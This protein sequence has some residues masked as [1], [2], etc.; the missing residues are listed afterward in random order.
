MSEHLFKSFRGALAPDA[1]LTPAVG[2]KL[3]AIVETCES[4]WTGVRPPAEEFVRHLGERLAGEPDPE[5]LL[6]SLFVEDLYLAY[7]CALGDRVA[8]AAFERE[9]LVHVGE[10]VSR[11]DGAAQH[12]DE[13]RQV[14]RERLLV[15]DGKPRVLDYSGRGALGGWV[16]V[17]AVR[18]ALNVVQRTRELA[19]P[20]EDLAARAV[21]NTPDPE[22]QLLQARYRGEFEAAVEEALGGLS[23]RDCNLM[24][25]HFVDGLSV[26]R[27][28]HAYGVH[29]VTVTRWLASARRQLL[30]RTRKILRVRLGLSPSEIDSLVKILQ[31]QLAISISQALQQRPE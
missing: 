21:A 12:L 25:L 26:E 30:A 7:A 17:A 22:L 29:R 9:V 27:I 4:R 24:R 3:A 2:E 10:F 15:G 14:L 31:S 28:R 1:K 11:I 6:G 13:I 20:H 23:S 8:I 16:R 5:A 18:Q 19:D